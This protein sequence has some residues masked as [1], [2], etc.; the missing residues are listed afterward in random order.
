[1]SLKKIFFKTKITYKIYLYYNLYIRH[2]CY[3]NRKNYSQWGEDKFIN[4]FF[5]K[6]NNGVYL[7]IGCFHPVMYSNTCLLHKRGWSGINIDINPTSIDLFNIVR[8]KDFNL[9]T[10]IDKDDKEFNLYYDDPFSPLNTLDREFYKKIKKKS[11]RI[12]KDITVKSKTIDKI[13]NESKINSK[14]DFINID[15]EGRDYEIL[16]NLKIDKLK[17]SLVSIETHNV[18]GTESTNYNKIKNFLENNK[19]ITYKRIGPSTL[20]KAI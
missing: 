13:I 11:N 16:K 4:D 9:C 2:K 5:I 10:T 12:F 7:D 14:I 1:M 3:I 15:V 19:F 17:P 6:K 20:Y 18:D 8:P